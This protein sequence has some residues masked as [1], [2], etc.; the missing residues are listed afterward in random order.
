ML[1][2]LLLACTPDPP[3]EPEVSTVEVVRGDTLGE[4]A[5]AN[6]VTVAD[7]KRWNG[8]TSD[9]IEVGQ[10]LRIEGG[11]AP[12]ASAGP[13]PRRP[14]TASGTSQGDDTPEDEP[15]GPTVP[16]LKK[17]RPKKCLAGPTDVEGDQGFAIAQGLTH[18]GTSAAMNAFLPNVGSCLVD[19]PPPSG[20]LNLEIA[21]GCDGV[22]DSVTVRG[23]HDWS[24]AHA[25]CL[26]EALQFAEFPAHARPDGDSFVYPLRLQ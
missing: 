7:L 3:P 19:L 10:V 5:K 1:A 16:R 22:V 4:L 23:G 11:E 26:V 21:V 15:G 14:R 24:T 8:L 13:R 17:P 12:V 18:E 20:P 6:G 2:L 25:D 9:L